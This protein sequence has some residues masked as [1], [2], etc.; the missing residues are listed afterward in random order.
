MQNILKVCGFYI[1]FM[2][3]E[4]LISFY[5]LERDLVIFTLVVLEMSQVQ[6][7]KAWNLKNQSQSRIQDQSLAKSRKFHRYRGKNLRCST[8]SSL[9]KSERRWRNA[10]NRES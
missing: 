10:S 4:T 1:N 3:F 5:D 2:Q 9:F 7:Q 6:T 8:T